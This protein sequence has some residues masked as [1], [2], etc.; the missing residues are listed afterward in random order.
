MYYLRLC[1]PRRHGRNRSSG[2]RAFALPLE[3]DCASPSHTSNSPG[4]TEKN[5]D[6]IIRIPV[7]TFRN[8]AREVGTGTSKESGGNGTFPADSQR[9]LYILQRGAL[10]KSS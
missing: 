3:F 6:V 2:D 7:L 10:V 1:Y 5:D 9:F 4:G 8:P